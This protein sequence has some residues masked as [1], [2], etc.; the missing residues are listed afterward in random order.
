MSQEVS[1]TA[2]VGGVSGSLYWLQHRHPRVNFLQEKYCLLPQRSSFAVKYAHASGDQAKKRSTLL[3]HQAPATSISADLPF[4]QFSYLLAGSGP[5][6]HSSESENQPGLTHHTS[7]IG[8]QVTQPSRRAPTL[9]RPS[10]RAGQID[11][12]SVIWKQNC[13]RDVGLAVLVA[14]GTEAVKSLV[15]KVLL[16][17]TSLVI[18]CQVRACLDGPD[19]TQSNPLLFPARMAF[20]HNLWRSSLTAIIVCL[21]RVRA[22]DTHYRVTIRNLHFRRA[23]PNTDGIKFSGHIFT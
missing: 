16:A 18:C 3:A 10:G 23:H 14:A 13:R 1:R 12:A 15:V 8:L 20:N 9:T 5:A 2:S 4:S 21:G 7:I 19:S 11:V 17:A 6:Q 22:C